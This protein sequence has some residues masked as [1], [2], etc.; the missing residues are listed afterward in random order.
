MEDKIIKTTELIKEVLEKSYL[1]SL[2][3]VDDSGVWASD[4]IYVFDEQL[5]IYW[6]SDPEVRHSRAILKN[7]HVSGTITTS[8]PQEKNMGIQFNGD[9][10]KIDGPRFD[11]AK[12]HYAKRGKAEP[13]EDD[14]VL[15]G[16]S[17]YM[18]KPKFIQLTYEKLFGFNK[19]DLKL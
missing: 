17:W 4:L 18:L 3:T 16:D 9:G 11:L 14:N 19:Q 15:L 10:Q 7:P 13:K 2:A 6:M 1:M 8:G 5:N 12:K